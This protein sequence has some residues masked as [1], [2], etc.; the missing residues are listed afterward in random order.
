MQDGAD[1]DSTVLRTGFS[2]IVSRYGHRG[3]RQSP[4]RHP[5][6][7][8]LLASLLRALSQTLVRLRLWHCLIDRLEFNVPQGVVAQ[9]HSLAVLHGS[10]IL[11]NGWVVL[12][13]DV[14]LRSTRNLLHSAGYSEVC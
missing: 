10:A 8:C 7:A 14:G 3:I 12:V 13:K 4:P 6:L 1:P 9:F 2:H 5:E 11:S